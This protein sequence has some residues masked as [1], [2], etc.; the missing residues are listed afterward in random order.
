[1]ATGILSSA[2]ALIGWSAPS[3]VLL[4]IALVGLAVLVALAT[5]RVMLFRSE[6]AS[7]A[8]DPARA[9]GFFTTVAAL[10]VVGIRLYTP[11]QPW[12]TIALAVISVPLW[13]L[14]A[15]GIPGALILGPREEPVANRVDGSW[16]LWVVGTQSVAI[17]AAITGASTGN[18]LL[19]D[20]AVALWGIGV[21]LYL[22]LA[23][24]VSLRLLTTRSEPG[25]FSPS[26]WIFMGATAISVLA[27]SQI[28]LLPATLPVVRATA[29]LVSGISYVL[30][31]FGTAWVPLLV[32][33]GVWRHLVKRV[34]FRYE[35]SLWSVVFPLGMYSVASLHFGAVANLPP[36]SAI[37]E[38]AVAVA[39]L[40]WAVVTV[41]A[42]RAVPHG[43]GR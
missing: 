4:I 39:A 42:L 15:Y 41:V 29:L 35:T 33:F 16:F 27:G 22:L 2:F 20:V 8:R 26:Y 23:A 19:A 9:F 36:L 38:G 17:V 34:P 7:D 1:M 24:L 5:T 21:V 12:V 43:A 10:N 31:A 18:S 32:I 11:A 6:I 3:F 37:G 14:L 25:S 13:V 40:A 30:W 28:L